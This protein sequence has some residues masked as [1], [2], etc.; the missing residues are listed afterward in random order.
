MRIRLLISAAAFAAALVL[1]SAAF[2]LDGPVVTAASPTNQVPVLNWLAVPAAVN[3]FHVLRGAGTCAVV[4]GSLSPAGGIDPLPG[5]TTFTDDISLPEGVYC[6]EV[7]SDDGITTT[8]SNQVDVNYDTT[9]PGV[10]GTPTGTSPVASTPSIAFTAATDPVSGG[11]N[12]G[13]D[14]Y[15]IY[16]DGV[17]VNVAP[18]PAGGPLTWTDD[19]TNSLNPASALGSDSYSYTVVAVD[20]AGNPSVPSGARTINV[21]ADGPNTPLAPTGS[22]PVASV[23]TITFSAVTDPTVGGVSSGVNHYDVYR[24]GVKMNNA[25]ITG[26]G[27]FTWHD[28]VAQSVTPA[29][30]SNA[31]SYTVV[32]V[33]NVNNASVASGALV[34]SMDAD[35]PNVPATPTGTSPVASV[36]TITFSAVTDPTVGGVSSGINHY[37]VYR[38]GVKVNNAVITGAGPFTWHDNVSESSSPASGSHAYSY[39]VVAV[40]NV[41]NQSTSTAR[42]I[43]LDGAPPLKPATPVGATLVS[44]DPSFTF[45]ATTDPTINTVT[46]GV[47]HYDIYRST[48]G[49]PSVKV[50]SGVISA[51]GLW[52]DVAGQSS[53][54]PLAG[55]HTYAYTVVAV[56][57][58]GNNSPASDPLSITLD[59]VGASAPTSVSALA[60]PTNQHPQISWAAPDPAA[61]TVDHYVV[62]RDGAQQ[63]GNIP[64][65]VTTFTD[66][67][68]GNGTYSYRVTAVDASS[69]AGT[70]SAQAVVTYDTAAPSAPAGPIASATLDGSIAVS[71]GVSGEAPARASRATSCAGR[72]RPSR[73]RR[74]RRR[75]RSARA[76]SRPAR[77]DALN[78]KLYSYAVFAVDAAGNTSAAGTTPASRRA[79]SSHPPHRRAWPRSRATRSS[80]SAGRRPGPATTSPATCSWPSRGEPL[81]R[82]T[83]TARASARARRDSTACSATGLTNGATYTFGLFALDEALNRSAAAAGQPCQTAR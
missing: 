12:S 41:G 64:N 39:T 38:G 51:A 70:A 63:G 35:A 1:P 6:Y 29:S 3:G 77:H 54:P 52:T 55:L 21:D 43:N 5:A 7:D 31:Y 80:T 13:I 24:G 72:S 8:P 65:T 59:T 53:S 37:D 33:D 30:G 66:L 75:R 57:G 44:S 16:R 20:G 81:R 79:T 15:D 49:G 28:N 69:V 34:I 76:S 11:T 56:D 47:D 67:T 2:A 19:A 22:T 4:G 26:A 61:I 78:G 14:H 46:S 9:P 36:P 50:N 18:I 58:V 60:T 23:P 42:V 73:R 10:P 71:W 48:G 17:Q 32:A 62:T 45:T 25:P 83:P 74:C 68:A 27:P 40:D 82:A